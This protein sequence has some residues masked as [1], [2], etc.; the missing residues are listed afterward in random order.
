MGFGKYFIWSKLDIVSSLCIFLMNKFPWITRWKTVYIYTHTHTGE[1][2]GF[3]ILCNYNL[4]Y[5]QLVVGYHWNLRY[6][7][8]RLCS[9][10]TTLTY[11]AIFIFKDSCLSSVTFYWIS[12]TTRIALNSIKISK[13]FKTVV[14]T[15]QRHLTDR[16]VITTV[17]RAGRGR[18][19]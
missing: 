3:V 2:T 13:Q 8:S 18:E 4:T 5:Q 1:L 14:G 12:C 11:I 10:I 19:R 17:G 15:W 16:R 9:A 6:F 7:A